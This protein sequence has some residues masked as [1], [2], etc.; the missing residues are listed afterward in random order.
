MTTAANRPSLPTPA[1]QRGAGV[2]APALARRWRRRSASTVPSPPA[3]T[4]VPSR[5][6]RASG[7]V[8]PS[9]LAL[10]TVRAC[11]FGVDGL[12]RRRLGLLGR[13]RPPAATPLQAAAVQPDPERHRDA[14]GAAGAAEAR[15]R[16]RPARSAWHRPGGGTRPCRPSACRPAGRRRAPRP[17]CPAP[18]ARRRGGRPPARRTALR[19]TASSCF[20]ASSYCLAS[21]SSAARRRRAS[22]RYSSSTAFSAT[23]A[24][25]APRVVGLALVELHLG[26]QHAGLLRIGGARITLLQVGEHARRLVGIA[27]LQRRVRARRT[28]RRPWRPAR[29]ATSSSRSMPA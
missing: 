17:S 6:A 28:S 20:S 19:A 14:P 1:E 12:Q 10:Q 2:G 9:S 18:A 23:Q 4:N 26:R 24:S 27:G 16:S 22:V 11:N 7:N 21:S 15:R 13:R 5:A 3:T 29:A 25:V 8:T